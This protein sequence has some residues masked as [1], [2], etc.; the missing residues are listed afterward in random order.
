MDTAS[1]AQKVNELSVVS[2]AEA[3]RRAGVHPKRIGRLVKDGRVVGATQLSDGTWVIPWPMKII[4]AGSGMS[5]LAK[6]AVD[7]DT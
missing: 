4:S 3:A 5:K 6:Y 7:G 1:Q 2:V